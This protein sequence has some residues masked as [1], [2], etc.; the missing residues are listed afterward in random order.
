MAKLGINF[1]ETPDVVLP[2]KPGVYTLDVVS[3][4]VEDVKAKPGNQ[5]LVVCLKVN[6]ETSSEHG[7]QI[8]DH[9]GLSGQFGPTRV[10]RLALSCGIRPGADGLD[11]ED[12]VGKTCKAR[13][14]NRTYQDPQ[15]GETRETSSIKDYEIPA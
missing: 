8:Y 12:L 2:I 5:K 10:K 14:E 1:D 11:V 13:I 9:I 7:R 6:D 15:T 4:V 3:A